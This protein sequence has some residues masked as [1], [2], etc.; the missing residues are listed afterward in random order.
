MAVIEVAQ[1]EGAHL[2][3]VNC[4]PVFCRR[5]VMGR[6][7][8]VGIAAAG[9]LVL[10]LGLSTL[11]AQSQQPRPVGQSDTQAKEV[12]LTGKIVDLH[13][14]MTGSQPTKDAV[15]CTRECLRDGVPAALEMD[16]GLVLLGKGMKG[17]GRE[18]AQ[19]AL[20]TVE[21]KGK[22]YEKHGLKY[23]DVIS[24]KEAKKAEPEE[25]EEGEESE[26]W[27]EDPEE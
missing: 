26:D 7:R 6:V 19:H 27:P 21:V 14:F 3:W 16:G 5:T 2:F 11:L 10:T 17:I 1:A 13:C 9:V 8:T 20:A 4:R 12:T 25:E 23:L 15:K 18:V 24:V 22:L